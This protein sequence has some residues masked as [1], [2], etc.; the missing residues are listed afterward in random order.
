VVA[1]LSVAYLIEPHGVELSASPLLS[2]LL[3]SGPNYGTTLL[4]CLGLG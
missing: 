1:R 4:A 2:E 3:W